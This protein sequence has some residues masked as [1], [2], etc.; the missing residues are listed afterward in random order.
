M[1]AGKNNVYDTKNVVDAANMSEVGNFV[2]MSTDK[3]VNPPNVMG[4]TKRFAE[5]IVQNVATR[6]SRQYGSVMCLD[7]VARLF[8]Y[9]RNR[10]RPLVRLLCRIHA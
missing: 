5:L 7:L 2:K 9:T 8:P 10:S 1:E 4:G 3:A 6:N